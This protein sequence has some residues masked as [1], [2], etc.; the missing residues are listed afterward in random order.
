MA[1]ILLR[2]YHHRFVLVL[3]APGEL[4]IQIW[5]SASLDSLDVK[6]KIDDGG[7]PDCDRIGTRKPSEKCGFR[8][9]TCRL[10]RPS[11]S[12]Q[13]TNMSKKSTK[14]WLEVL[15][16]QKLST[17]FT[18][19]GS[20]RKYP[21]FSK[22]QILS[23][24]LSQVCPRFLVISQRKVFFVGMQG[25][26][27]IVTLGSFVQRRSCQYTIDCGD[28]GHSETMFSKHFKTWDKLGT[29]LGQNLGQKL[30]QLLAA[31]SPRAAP[32]Y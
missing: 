28:C 4:V 30:G 29:N 8:V 31:V 3:Y 18:A 2:H 12:R 5:R 23:Q 15:H 17:P 27:G 22:L 14:C 24:V 7:R 32:T 20:A 19:D 16:H 25:R 1:W 11:A 6:K 9:P 21:A 13:L 26:A 10:W